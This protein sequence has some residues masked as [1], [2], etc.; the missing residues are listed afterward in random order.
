MQSCTNSR[1]CTQLLS[2]YNI[3]ILAY[4][5]E[6]SSLKHLLSLNGALFHVD[7]HRE[8]RMRAW[9]AGIEQCSG[10]LT[11][12][13]TTFKDGVYFILIM[14]DQLFKSMDH[15]RTLKRK[16][17]F[18]WM[19]HTITVWNG[20]IRGSKYWCGVTN[21]TIEGICYSVYIRLTF[22]AESSEYPQLWIVLSGTEKIKELFIVEFQEGNSHRVLL[23]VVGLKLLKELV[24]W[25]R[26]DTSQR[27][28]DV[29]SVGSIYTWN[30]NYDLPPP[31]KASL[32]GSSLPP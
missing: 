28:L 10:S 12:C 25:A 31:M 30:L 14:D 32:P 13:G 4:K 3:I 29:S 9:G 1:P 27:I 17:Q 21:S 18:L 26:D 15:H 7:S 24:K 5:V 8:D 11:P 22:L 23:N 16:E 2:F 19:N 20:L 6:F